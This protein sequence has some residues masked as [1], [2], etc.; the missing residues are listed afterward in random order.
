MLREQQLFAKFRKRHFSKDIIQYLGHVVSKDGIFFNLD[1][2]KVITRCLVLKNV[3]DIRS[4][5]GITGYYRKFIKVFSKIAYPITSLEK[6]GKK[7][8]WNEKCMESFNKLKHLLTTSYILK[9][10]DPFKDFLVC[11]NV[12]KEGLGRVLIQENYIVAY[13]YRKLK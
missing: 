4:F 8:D 6:K 7:F 11:T 3:T 13:G 1:K 9:I 5:M 2:I 12:C 10:V